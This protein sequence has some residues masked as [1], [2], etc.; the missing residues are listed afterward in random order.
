MITEA[1]IATTTATETE[2]G[3]LATDDYSDAA[4]MRKVVRGDHCGI[5]HGSQSWGGHRVLA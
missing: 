4:T 1:E 5:R 2:V 3:A